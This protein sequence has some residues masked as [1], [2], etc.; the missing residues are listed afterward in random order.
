MLGPPLK[1][2][3]DPPLPTPM[4]STLLEKQMNKAV[5]TYLESRQNMMIELLALKCFHS[6]LLPARLC[7]SVCM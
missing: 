4:N 7:C 1:L 2:L 3:G 5:S 6:S